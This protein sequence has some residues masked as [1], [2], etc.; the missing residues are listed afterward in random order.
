M[1]ELTVDATIES[2]N[3]ITT[4]VDNQLSAWHC[5]VKVQM[6]FDIA[7]DEIV[8]N[9]SRYAYSPQTGKVTVRVEMAQEPLSVTLSF[10]DN[11][12]PFDPLKMADPDV[13]QPADEREIGGLGIYM[14]KRSMDSIAYK[15][16]DGTNILSIRKE[17]E[18]IQAAE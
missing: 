3:K 10:M 5:P 18:P 6:Q 17:I 13:T 2:I 7:I 14:V 1:S 16:K 8:S 11:G 4:Y 12:A 15:Y 9:I